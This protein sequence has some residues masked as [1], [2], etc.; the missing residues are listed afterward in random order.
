MRRFHFDVTDSTNDQ[1]R[2]LAGSHPGE[3][4]LVTAA[5]QTGGR[6]RQG[7]AW[8][9]PR[10][11]AWLSVVWPLDLAANVSGVSLAAAVAVR[12]ALCRVAPEAAER[13]LIKWPNDVLLDDRKVCGIL[14]EGFPARGGDPASP[15][16]L[17][18]GVGV[19]VDFDVVQLAGDLRHPATTLRSALDRSIAVDA[20]IDAASSEL[21]QVLTNWDQAGL[22]AAL[23]WELKAHLAY[24]GTERTWNGP[25]GPVV[26]RVLGVDANGRL[27]LQGREGQLVCEVGEFA[28]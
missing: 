8:Q 23:I 15:G 26:G 2:R 22:D 3:P 27:L 14:C 17:V 12:R 11:G 7:R 19:N 9:S 28:S 13:L 20:V 6:G 5:E 25:A 21:E 18:I 24:V 16:I 4:L 1:A 10:G